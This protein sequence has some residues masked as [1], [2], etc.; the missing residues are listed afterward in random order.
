[1]TLIITGHTTNN[2]PVKEGSASPLDA[3][4]SGYAQ[5][6]WIIERLLNIAEEE[7]DLRPITVRVGQ[8]CGSSNGSWNRNEWF[9]SLVI[10]SKHLGCL[11]ALAQVSSAY[12]NV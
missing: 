7:T 5:S 4:S 12:N 1:M 9:P 3:V 2:G 8:I 6:K 10:S 11:P